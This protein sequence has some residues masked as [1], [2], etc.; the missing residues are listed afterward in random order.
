MIAINSN[1]KLQ[2][3][4][5]DSPEVTINSNLRR[6]FKRNIGLWNSQRN[7]FLKEKS[8]NY[9]ICMKLEIESLESKN[10]WESHYKFTW[11][12]SEKYSFFKENPE[13][14]EK[15]EM[16]AYIQGHQL[17]RENFYLS[18]KKGISNIRQVDEHEMIFESTYDNWHI[19]E[20]TRLV[21]MDN[22][23]FRV[24]YSWND[25][26]LKIVESHHETRIIS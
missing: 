5:F 18:D 4:S 2:F 26:N 9:N 16:K 8:K 14:K 13:Y 17:I 20:H 3:G 24:I 22:L 25:N 23:R 11:Q 21:D 15:G 10:A 19:L 6:W 12:P 7:Y 1:N